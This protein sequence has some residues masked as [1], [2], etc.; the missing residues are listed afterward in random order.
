M[1]MSKNNTYESEKDN[2]TFDPEVSIRENHSGAPPNSRLIVKRGGHSIT[3]Q[4]P[5]PII[6]APEEFEQALLKDVKK[7]VKRQESVL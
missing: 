6:L 7:W 2:E 3:R 5:K 4:I 1:K